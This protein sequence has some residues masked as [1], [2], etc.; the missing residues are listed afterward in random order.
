M[1]RL[2][3]P[4]LNLGHALTHLVMLIFPTA[5]LALG[6]AWGI[7]YDRLMPASLSGLIAY[8]AG[9]LP[10]GWLGDRWSRR[11][12]MALF[13]IGIGAGAV[14]CGAARRR[15]AGDAGAL[16]IGPALSRSRQRCLRP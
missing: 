15:H 1:P 13:F 10:S 4:F 6:P 7:A 9:S 11:S 16:G 8:G 14:L 5:V 12:M 3:V 2:L